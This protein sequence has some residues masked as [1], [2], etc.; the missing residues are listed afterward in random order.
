M[1]QRNDL[2]VENVLWW[3]KNEINAR[4]FQQ[5]PMHIAKTMCRN[6]TY[7]S[8][9]KGEVIIRQGD[10]AQNFF[11]VISGKVNVHIRDEDDHASD[12]ASQAGSLSRSPTAGSSR[13]RG[14][15][16]NS[17]LGEGAEG[18]A[19]G[20]EGGGGSRGASRSGSRAPSR[21]S[22]GGAASRGGLRP[23]GGGTLGDPG[24]IDGGLSPET[25]LLSS[26]PEMPSGGHGGSGGV[27][28]VSAD[29]RS[30]GGADSRTPSL[31]GSP[32]FRRETS[33]SSLSEFSVLQRYGKCVSDMSVGMVF[34]EMSIL[35]DTVR[36]AS[37]VAGE[38][39]EIMCIPREC[40]AKSIRRMKE[41]TVLPDSVRLILLK[42][43]FS[44][45]MEEV[46]LCCKVI[47]NIHFFN[48]LSRQAM[49]G[50][51][52]NM[53]LRSMPDNSVLF[54]QGDT[55][56]EF[57][58][59]LTGSVSIHQRRVGMTPVAGQTRGGG[60]A[61]GASQP[62]SPTKAE[63]QN[64]E[65]QYGRCVTTLHPGDG[66]GERALLQTS[67]RE[68]SAITS[69]PVEL[70]VVHKMGFNTMIHANQT[71]ASVVYHPERLRRLL[72]K[73]P[74]ERTAEDLS[75]LV[76]YTAGLQFF[77]ELSTKK[78]LKL[79]KEVSLNIMRAA[80]YNRVNKD[81][82]IVRQGDEGATFYI[83]I[84]G[85]V[86]I[87]MRDETSV[88]IETALRDLE[89]LKMT[90][91]VHLS[92]TEIYG[93]AIKFLG[94]GDSFGELAL[95]RE[96]GVGEGTRTATVIAQE[97]TDLLT[98]Q[99]EEYH[100]AVR[101]VQQQA[102]FDRINLIQRIPG[103]KDWPYQKLI[104]TAYNMKLVEVP[105]GAPIITEGLRVNSLYVVRTGEVKVFKSID[106]ATAEAE[107]DAALLQA[108]SAAFMGAG[109]AG[110]GKAGGPGSGSGGVPGALGLDHKSTQLQLEDGK[111]WT[112]GKVVGNH[113]E[114]ALSKQLVP[115]SV[116]GVG[117]IFGD[118]ALFTDSIQPCTVVAST[119][120]HIFVIDGE[121][122]KRNCT[123]Q[124]SQ[125]LQKLS[126]LKL[127]QMNE[128][129]DQVHGAFQR[130][131]QKLKT[132]KEAAGPGPRWKYLGAR[133]APLT[134]STAGSSLAAPL[135]AQLG[136][137]VG[138]G[139]CAL[140][141]KEEDSRKSLRSRALEMSLRSH[142]GSRAPA[143]L[144]RAG[145]GAA[146]GHSLLAHLAE[147]GAPP[148]RGASSG[149]AS[150]TGRVHLPAIASKSKLGGGGNGARPGRLP[151][152]P[153]ATEDDAPHPLPEASSSRFF[154]AK[155][156]GQLKQYNTD[157]LDL[158]KG[159]PRVFGD[160]KLVYTQ[161]DGEVP[162]WTRDYT[163]NVLEDYTRDFVKHSIRSGQ[164]LAS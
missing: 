158:G 153:S 93:S 126:M 61:A 119:F 45:A 133:R 90:R 150:H 28:G 104:K 98:L 62:G 84:S 116:L 2:D 58:V 137:A 23:V 161:R 151:G 50:V 81:T 39:T 146:G 147:E 30:P 66:F 59:I 107:R 138:L 33:Q 152:S 65:Q 54:K 83:I 140:S 76:D 44:R 101:Q 110:G 47:A 92:Q 14:P 75:Q 52:Q 103:A 11:L 96:H 112:G 129:Y 31:P 73:A 128:R 148:A 106:S 79:S 99:K 85:K 37:C 35:Q 120:C 78:K 22:G 68:A 89:T 49:L 100:E 114:G 82:P 87:H 26:V 127:R 10:R 16:R 74:D 41:T 1:T 20:A 105:R 149:G 117:E 72:Q 160:T 123:H 139:T 24:S 7:R 57:F 5:V 34:G 124:M 63:S 19:L 155:A 122:F 36:L 51:V 18:G 77:K 8:V 159:T 144:G 43:P 118:Y 132:G 111:G 86:S 154:G 29:L 113:L 17:A 156:K 48:K 64:L 25:A 131:T 102:I 163:R 91:G 38:D 32:P 141:N 55:G 4:F 60:N 162:R 95:L 97:P 135:D 143:G 136:R 121:D 134:P 80:R 94:P 40:Y 13:P 15:S 145:G 46:E 42:E 125:A 53:R 109:G 142:R 69:S 115:I 9:Q 67:I 27:D 21:Q 108:G 88:P 130:I 164:S 71:E 70:L 157:H 6:G 56:Q 12:T 3:F